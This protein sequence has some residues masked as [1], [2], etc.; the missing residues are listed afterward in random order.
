VLG[1]AVCVGDGQAVFHGILGRIVVVRVVDLFIHNGLYIRV[2]GCVDLQSA[3]VEKVAGLAFRVVQL[4]HQV[5]D[6]LFDQL[7]CEIA[8]RGDALLFDR[9]HVLDAAVDVVRQSL[10]LLVL[11]DII[12][13][14]HVLQH[15]GPALRVGL[16]PGDGV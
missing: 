7:V 13:L 16:G 12:L 1:F 9:V 8:V 4:F 15:D 6:D 3:G 11:G 2:L 5:L 14:K 10:F